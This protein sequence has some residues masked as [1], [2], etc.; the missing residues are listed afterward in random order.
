MLMAIPGH[1][2]VGRNTQQKLGLM[3]SILKFAPKGIVHSGNSG[4]NS[5]LASYIR[6]TFGNLS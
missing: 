3:S 6:A 4:D 2:Y 1:F 5:H